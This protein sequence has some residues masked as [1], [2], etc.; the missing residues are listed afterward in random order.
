MLIRLVTSKLPFQHLKSSS[1]L[2][3]PQIIRENFKDIFKSSKNSLK[4][5]LFIN[6]NRPTKISR[7]TFALGFLGTSVLIK[8]KLSVVKCDTRIAELKI[9]K[10]IKFEWKL[11]WSYLSKH[12]IKL[13]G[14]I[15][16]S[17][18]VA[19]LNISIPS[20]LGQL[21]NTLSKYAGDIHGTAKDF[22]NV[23]GC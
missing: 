11:F 1:I 22:L 10:E 17:L 4:G 21:I 12:I 2:R 8:N 15:A 20:L 23:S 13:L 18:V 5:N 6:K 7:L 9:N 19:Y 3:N 16:A 14:A